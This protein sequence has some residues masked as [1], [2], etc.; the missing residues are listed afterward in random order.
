MP[1]QI[2]LKSISLGKGNK[3]GFIMLD[4]SLHYAVHKKQ[5]NHEVYNFGSFS[6][7]I[8]MILLPW[9]TNPEE[10]LRNY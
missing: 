7:L 5:K 1:Y 10:V 8:S 2:R 9:L 4:A 6:W 3:L